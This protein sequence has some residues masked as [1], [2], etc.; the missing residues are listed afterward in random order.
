[1]HL[2]KGCRLSVTGKHPHHLVP[3]GLKDAT[4]D[5]TVIRRWNA[6]GGLNYGVCTD[7][8]VVLDQDGEAGRLSLRKLEEKHGRLPPTWTVSTGKRQSRHRYFTPPGGSAIRCSAGSLA[9]DWMSAP[10]AAT[11]W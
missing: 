4:T 5:A 3:A 6:T 2:P 10:A 7:R 11:W 8:L 1:M 9:R